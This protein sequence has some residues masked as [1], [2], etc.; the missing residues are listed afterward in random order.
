MIVHPVVT[1]RRIIKPIDMVIINYAASASE[2]VV[3]AYAVARVIGVARCMI[4]RPVIARTIIAR[5]VI[6][7]RIRALSLIHI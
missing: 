4:I 7:I 1:M 5:P 3:P 6:V 2:D